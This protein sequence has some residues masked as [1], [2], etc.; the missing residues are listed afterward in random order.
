MSERMTVIDVTDHMDRAA[1]ADEIEQLRAALK[2]IVADVDEDCG[3][4]EC[5]DCKHWRLAWAALARNSENCAGAATKV[6]G[7]PKGDA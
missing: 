2:A 5:P 7:K 6:G 1:L 4:P 3:D